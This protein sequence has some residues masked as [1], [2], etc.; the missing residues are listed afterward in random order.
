MNLRLKDQRLLKKNGLKI[1]NKNFFLKHVKPAR[2][3]RFL[4]SI[5]KKSKLMTILVK[6]NKAETF[7]SKALRRMKLRMMVFHNNLKCR[8]SRYSH[9]KILWNRIILL[10]L[11]CRII[12]MINL[13]ITPKWPRICSNTSCNYNTSS[14]TSS[15]KSRFT[16]LRMKR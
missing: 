13:R 6:V 5:I 10:V 11:T 16:I 12:Q 14:R 15:R 1:W 4:S 7:S 3:R 2:H 9:H 8:I